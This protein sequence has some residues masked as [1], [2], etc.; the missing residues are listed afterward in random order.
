MYNYF[1]NGESQSYSF[2]QSNYEKFLASNDDEAWFGR[3]TGRTGYI[4]I[5]ESAQFSNFPENSLYKR[6]ITN[7]GAGDAQI[8]GFGKYRVI[9]ANEKAGFL[10][11]KPIEG[12]VITG[13][14]TP[15]KSINV[16]T[17]VTIHDTEFTFHRRSSIDASGN[18][19]ITIPY[20]GEYKVGESNMYVTEDAVMNGSKIQVGSVG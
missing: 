19:S 10:V 6:F 9:Y 3:L 15:N 5:E 4:V 8:N 13:T 16:T 18:F 2:A 14:G 11:V 1:I 17:R 20:P 12:A 7:Y